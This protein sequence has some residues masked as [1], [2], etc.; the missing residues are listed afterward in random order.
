MNTSPMISDK[1]EFVTLPL[2][3]AV[4]F[5]NMVVPLFIGRKKSVAVLEHAV[6]RDLDIFVV[7]QKEV[8]TEEPTQKDL[9]SIGTIAKVLQ[10][11]KLPDGT[12]KVLIEG[13]QRGRLEHFYTE[14]RKFFI[15]E[16]T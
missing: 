5:P 2:R 14:D 8:S 10:M 12:L 4:L 3:D 1:A 15:S 13:N 9:Y 7:T 6:E 16:V 11:L